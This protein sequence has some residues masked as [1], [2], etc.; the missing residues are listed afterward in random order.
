MRTNVL[1]PELACRDAE[2]SRAFYLDVLGFGVRYERPEQGF[3]YLT[4]EGADI[5]LEPMGEGTWLAA[6]A[7][8][9]FG[10]GIHFQ[11]MVSDLD[12]LLA[13]CQAKGA[14]IF[15][16]YEEAWYRAGGAWVGQSQFVVQDPDGYLLRFAQ[17]LGRSTTRPMTGRVV[18]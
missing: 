6:P 18:D 16:Q 1:V 14:T 2:V 13:R 10:R 17:D 8:P 9:P 7:E 15:R 11:I 3:C 4:R 12:A 5:M